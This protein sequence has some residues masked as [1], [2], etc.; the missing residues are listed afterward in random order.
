MGKSGLWE[1]DEQRRLEIGKVTPSLGILSL[2]KSPGC[3]K[4]AE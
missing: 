4:H 1:K 2:S 3:R